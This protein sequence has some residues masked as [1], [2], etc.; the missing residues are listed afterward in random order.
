MECGLFIDPNNVF[1]GATP[2]GL[3]GHDTLV[4]FKCPFTAADM[5]LEEAISKKKNTFF[6]MNKK[7]RKN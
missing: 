1:L 2:D 6:K 4:E 7:K 5:D 3:I